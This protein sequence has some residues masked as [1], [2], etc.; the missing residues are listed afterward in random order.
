MNIYGTA[1]YKDVPEIQVLIPEFTMLALVTASC[2]S[3]SQY[4]S[5]GQSQND[6]KTAGST[7]RLHTTTTR[8]TAQTSQITRF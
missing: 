7:S 2:V 3:F 4:I 6:M 8:S 5:S 1:T